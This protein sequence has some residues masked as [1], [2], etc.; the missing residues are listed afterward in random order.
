MQCLEPTRRWSLN[1]L[2]LSD[3][4]TLYRTGGGTGV[5]FYARNNLEN[6]QTEFP[7]YFM[8]GQTDQVLDKESEDSKVKGIEEKFRF[9]SRCS[10][11]YIYSRPS[12]V[13]SEKG[14]A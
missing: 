13:I 9:D 11:W 1:K 4:G 7:K 14:K 6:K 3:T 12:G 5:Q 10:A 2:P 8:H